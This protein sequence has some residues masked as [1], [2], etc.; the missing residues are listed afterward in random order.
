MLSKIFPDRANYSGTIK[1]QCGM[2]G[3]FLSVKSDGAYSYH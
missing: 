2:N 1:E 3:R